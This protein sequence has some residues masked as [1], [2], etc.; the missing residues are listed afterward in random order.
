MTGGNGKKLEKLHL[1][2]KI[3]AYLQM[4]TCTH[5]IDSHTHRHTRAGQVFLIF[6]KEMKRCVLL[7]TITSLQAVHQIFSHAF[8]DDISLQDFSGSE[9]RLSVY[10]LDNVATVFYELENYKDVKNLSVLKIFERKPKNYEDITHYQQLQQLQLQQQPLNSLH[11]SAHQSKKTHFI[12]KTNSLQAL[13]DLAETEENLSKLKAPKEVCCFGGSSSKEKIHKSLIVSTTKRN[14]KQQIQ[15]PKETTVKSDKILTQ[16]YN[17]SVKKLDKESIYYLP[18]N[19]NN[20]ST[21]NKSN[22]SPKTKS[23]SQMSNSCYHSSLDRQNY[24]EPIY[25]HYHHHHHHGQQ[26]N[27]N[28]TPKIDNGNNGLRK[29]QKTSGRHSYSAN[30]SPSIEHSCVNYSIYGLEGCGKNNKSPAS[31]CC[32]HHC[33]HQHHNNQFFQCSHSS[34]HQCKH[35]QHASSLSPQRSSCRTQHQQQQQQQ[36]QHNININHD[37]HHSQHHHNSCHSLPET[38]SKQTKSQTGSFVDLIPVDLLNTNFKTKPNVSKATEDDNLNTQLR[39]HQLEDQLASLTQWIHGSLNAEDKK[40][41]NEL[42][43]LSVEMKNFNVEINDGSRKLNRGDVGKSLPD[44][45]TNLKN[46]LENVNELKSQCLL[47]KNAQEIQQLEVQNALTEFACQ[48]MNFISRGMISENAFICNA[49]AFDPI[50][51]SAVIKQAM[52]K[53]K[54]DQTYNN[55]NVLDDIV[56]DTNVPKNVAMSKMKEN[57][58]VVDGQQSLDLITRSPD[59]VSSSKQQS[60]CKNLENEIKTIRLKEARYVAGSI[61]ENT[62]ATNLDGMDDVWVQMK[63]V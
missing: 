38:E 34:M 26:D 46:M 53:K 20:K 61:E 18:S 41:S 49:I 8:P 54:K 44:I 60:S 24:S 63:N 21:A 40:F 31:P 28:N 51:S 59:L 33:Q 14:Q 12:V 10:I 42:P 32:R 29:K 1:S 45:E 6:G 39:I 3:E 17:V 47:L 30:S 22:E 5:V 43:P 56:S 16:D 57:L 2:A 36:Q 25:C 52:M 55:Q 37:S 35:F 9:S 13:P 27:A 11:A 15:Q 58:F 62:L 48:I 19:S 7:Q 50:P 4:L 23:A